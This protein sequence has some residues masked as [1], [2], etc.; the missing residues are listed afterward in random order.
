MPSDTTLNAA[1]DRAQASPIWLGLVVLGLTTLSAASMRTVFSPVQELAK[2]DLS[3]SDLQLSLVQ[4]L[5]I[6]IP[7]ALLSIPLGRIADRGN[8][9]RLLLAL[10]A[11][12]TIGTVATAFVTDFY[13]LFFAR[14]LAGIG[15]LCALPV[16]ISIA[17]DLST[18][19]NRGRSLLILSLGNMGG[20]AAAFAFGGIALGALQNAPPLIDGQAPWRGVHLLFGAASMVLL[21]PLLIM[22]E[23]ARKEISETV[24]TSLGPA[25]R[26]IW[27]RRALLAPLFVGQVSVVMADTAATIWAA[28]VLSRSYGVSPE[29]FAGWM[30]LVILV[31][32]VL[33]SFLGGFAA[34]AGH[35]STVKAGILIGAVIASLVSVVGAFF[36]LA[37][38]VPTFAALLGLLLLCGAITGLVTATAI[39]VLV[40]N[41]IR[42][43][44]LSAFIVLG[45]IVGFGVAPTVVTLISETI[46]GAEAIRYGLAAT[47]AATT[48]ASA[49]GF[50]TAMLHARKS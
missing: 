16:A 50:I 11:I 32:A 29:E 8:R 14:M 9:L 3:L 34:D 12:W 5:A 42:G 35:K 40:P 10:S 47:T 15:S 41:E 36:P 17:A 20:A 33:G 27:A 28:P 7:V 49:G 2:A 48:L 45:A 26:A 31:S 38:D 13:A 24:H 19:D 30:G 1:P 44:C 37:P 4:G 43:V 23:P 46:G 39:S 6:S 22:R 21:L 18:P 25:L